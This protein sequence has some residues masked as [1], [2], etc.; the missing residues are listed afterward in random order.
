MLSD[1]QTPDR[2]VEI[3][4]TCRRLAGIDFPWDVNR[5]LELALLKTFCLPAISGLLATTGE[6]VER[7]RKRYDDTA[8]MVAELL[9]HGMDSP[10]GKAVIS[11]M[12]SIHGHY[13]IG[14]DDFLY[15]LSSFVAEPIR[16]LE[17]YGWRALTPLEQQH[18]FLFWQAVGERM[19]I[20]SIP[21]SLEDLLELNQRVE[22]SAFRSAACNRTIAE[23]TLAMLLADWPAPLRPVLRRS[24][25]GLL[26]DDTA[27]ALGW[28]VA[29]GWI[30][31][32]VL[33]VLRMRSRLSGTW[34]AIDRQLGRRPRSRL[35]SEQPTP[36]YGASFQLEQ[37][38]PPGML[39]E[40]NQKTEKG[41]G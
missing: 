39:A 4:L 28:V 18:L 1:S 31:G 7:P 37:L 19:G 25:M 6:F 34:Q 10:M 23:A 8:L 12:N 11:R 24:L 9:R 32:V 38:G 21:E 16:W 14:N 15:V 13:R 29:P 41:C 27:S 20:H 30:Q 5:S 35:Y 40:L 3:E 22:T 33:R 36:S 17:R 2:L 26:A